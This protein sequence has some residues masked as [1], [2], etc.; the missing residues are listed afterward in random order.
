VNSGLFAP[1]SEASRSLAGLALSWTARR[2]KAQTPIRTSPKTLLGWRYY[3]IPAHLVVR[4]SPAATTAVTA[5]LPSRDG[6]LPSIY[7]LLPPGPSFSYFHCLS[8]D[9]P[10]VFNG[11][12]FLY[13]AI[14]DVTG[15]EREIA[16]VYIESRWLFEAQ[17]GMPGSTS[18][19]LP[20]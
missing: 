5:P 11:F 16:G 15:F 9:S 12:Q 19:Y 1:N 2:T 6:G 18:I 14:L 8:I 4:V 7:C 20:R 17:L 3:H 13:T 10:L